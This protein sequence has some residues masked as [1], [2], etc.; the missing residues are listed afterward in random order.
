MAYTWLLKAVVNQALEINAS[1]QNNYVYFILSF[2]SYSF[3]IYINKLV[4]LLL[5]SYIYFL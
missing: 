4:T 2:Q 3:Q 1:T 5:K